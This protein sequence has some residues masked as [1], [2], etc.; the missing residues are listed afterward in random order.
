MIGSL[1]RRR[2]CIFL[3]FFAPI[4]FRLPSLLFSLDTT[5]ADESDTRMKMHFVTR[6]TMILLSHAVVGETVPV[7]GVS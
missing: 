3:C 2:F 6:S 1:D 5:F 7:E 4:F